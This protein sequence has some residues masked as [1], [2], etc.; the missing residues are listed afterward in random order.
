[1]LETDFDPGDNLLIDTYIYQMKFFNV[2]KKKYEKKI[3]IHDFI[4]EQFSKQASN[5]EN[6]IEESLL[7]KKVRKS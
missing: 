1:M 3:K 2:M 4:N 6:E 5:I 7:K